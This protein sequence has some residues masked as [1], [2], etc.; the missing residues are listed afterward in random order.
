MSIMSTL[1]ILAVAAALV[2]P[3]AGGD[4]FRWSGA[5]APGKVLEIKGVNG[6]IKAGAASGSEVASRAA[7]ATPPK[8]RSR[9][10]STAGE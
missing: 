7:A 8:W 10:S 2:A 4:D 1:G 6:G 9:W 5:V 3:P